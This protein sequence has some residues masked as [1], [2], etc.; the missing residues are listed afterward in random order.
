V[1]GK[2]KIT[3]KNIDPYTLGDFENKIWQLIKKSCEADEDNDFPI[4][5][6][7]RDRKHHYPFVQNFL[8]P[9]DEKEIDRAIELAVSNAKSA[10]DQLD[11]LIRIKNLKST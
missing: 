7:L 5:F 9:I 8:I 10:V 4:A 6:M 11:L 2:N 3:W 1:S